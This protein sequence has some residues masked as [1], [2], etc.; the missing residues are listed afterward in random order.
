VK[1]E[2]L[3]LTLYE[4]RALGVCYLLAKQSGLFPSFMAT[5]E[6]A[7]EEALMAVSLQ[8]ALLKLNDAE[9]RFEDVEDLTPQQR[10]E[11]A[12]ARAQVDQDQA[13]LV[14]PTRGEAA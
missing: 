5:L 13:W 2:P 6:D 9:G 4:I 11:I 3:E 8:S 7:D 12:A 1:T 14:D 10:L